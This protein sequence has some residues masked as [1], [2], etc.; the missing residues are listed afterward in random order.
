M[1]VLKAKVVFAL[2]LDV[3]L[4]WHYKIQLKLSDTEVKYHL[5]LLTH[6]PLNLCNIFSF[7]F[8]FQLA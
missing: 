4:F 2:V 8:V 6:K 3:A 7:L 5:L 1:L